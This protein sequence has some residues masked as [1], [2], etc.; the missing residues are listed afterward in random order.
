[1]KRI[2]GEIIEAKKQADI[3]LVSFHA[4][5]YDVTDT[6]VPA[7]FLEVFSRRCIDAGAS[8]V[9]GHG[10]HEIRGIELYHGGLIFYSLGNFIFETETVEYQPWDAYANRGM[11]LDTKVGAYMDDRSK[12]GTVGYGTLPEIWE[13]V[14]GAFTIEDGRLTEVR[15]YPIALGMD[16]SRAQ[17]G[18]PYLTGDEKLLER[19][20]KLC[21]PYGTELVIENGVGVVKL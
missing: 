13:A 14:M 8:A 2:E 6:T 11:S 3:V 7:H 12:N 18:V 16:K 4:H 15:L 17:K 5:E 20:G 1:M 9:L 21:E 19:L 10:P